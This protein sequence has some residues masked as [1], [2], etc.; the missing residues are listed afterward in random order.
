MSSHEVDVTITPQQAAHGVILTVTLPTGPARLRIPSGTRDGD[1]VRVRVGSDE[2]P[3]RVSVS[4]PAPPPP[5]TPAAQPRPGG[6][7]PFATP[8]PTPTPSPQARPGDGNPFATPTPTPSPQPPPG[9]GNPFA[10]RTQQMPAQPGGGNPFAAAPVPARRAGGGRRGSVGFLVAGLIIAAV[11]VSLVGPGTGDSGDGKASGSATASESSGPEP[12]YSSSY[13]PSYS[14]S[15]APASPGYTAT[16]EPAPV[17]EPT[18]EAAPTPYDKG[19]CLNGTLPDS[20]TAQRV[21]DVEE[22]PCSAADAHYRVIGSIPMTSDMDRCEDY[23]KTQYAFSHRYTLNGAV[24][25]QYVYC[26][27]GLGSYARD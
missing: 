18:E 3:V 15:G 5:A 23:P 7:N 21:D 9:G 20:T 13:S 8:T 12:S 27:V 1:L 4:A 17:P 10:A 22:V 11:L 14:P 16:A 26:L 6:G 2:V 19:T 25:N 24:I